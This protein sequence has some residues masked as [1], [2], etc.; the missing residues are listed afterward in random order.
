MV[1]D[2]LVYHVDVLFPIVRNVENLKG[3]FYYYV[4]H[5][6]GYLI[7][8]KLILLGVID[9]SN[10][11]EV[12]DLVDGSAKFAF[13]PGLLSDWYEEKRDATGFH[14]KDVQV[15]EVPSKR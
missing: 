11:S 1:S 9:Q 12:V 13:Y 7:N 4:I 14:R 2:S 8:V 10:I 5:E 3:M 15:F 6:T